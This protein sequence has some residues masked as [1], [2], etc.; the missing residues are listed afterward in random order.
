MFAGFLLTFASCKTVFGF[1]NDALIVH[2][3]TLGP[4]QS[5]K[6]KASGCEILSGF[7]ISDLVDTITCF[8]SCQDWA[9]TM[10][11]SHV[12]GTAWIY[13]DL[14]ELFKLDSKKQDL[15]S[16]S[17]QMLISLVFFKNVSALIAVV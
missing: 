11:L 8:L 10:I 14:C 4:Y 5:Q 1:V 2:G 17:S 16:S 15:S 13:E 12:T 6:T 3:H 7:R 9:K